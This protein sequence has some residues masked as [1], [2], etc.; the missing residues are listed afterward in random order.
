MKKEYISPRIEIFHTNYEEFMFQ[1]FGIE[2]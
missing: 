1:N 2:L